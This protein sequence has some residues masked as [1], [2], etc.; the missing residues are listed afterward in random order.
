MDV[1]YIQLAPEADMQRQHL[2]VQVQALQKKVQIE[3]ATAPTHHRTNYVQRE[4]E[5]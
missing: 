2:Q 1:S 3:H 4:M 5:K